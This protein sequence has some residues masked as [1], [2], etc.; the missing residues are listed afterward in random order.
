MHKIDHLGHDFWTRLIPQITHSS[1]V[2]RRTV[3]AAASVLD[4]FQSH[5]QDPS[6][7]IEARGRYRMNVRSIIKSAEQT[8][9]EFALLACLVFAS[10]ELVMGAL[11]AGRVHLEAGSKILTERIAYLSRNDLRRGLAAS[12]LSENI[13]PIFAAYSQV[14]SIN[15]ISLVS[16]GAPSTMWV[17]QYDCVPIPT[18]FVTTDQAYAHLRSTIHQIFVKYSTQSPAHFEQVQTQLDQW[19]TALD[20][21]ERCQGLSHTPHVKSSTICFFRNQHR[22]AQVFLSV[23]RGSEEANPLLLEDFSFDF[24]WIL[25][26]YDAMKF[27]Q[28]LLNE[29]VELIPPLFIIATKTRSK[30]ISNEAMRLLE[31][32][33]RVEANWDS[34]TALRI[35][36]ELIACEECSSTSP[37]SSSQSKQIQLPT[38]PEICLHN[39]SGMWVS[40]DSPQYTSGKLT[41]F[42]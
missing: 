24:I 22:L 9:P 30:G 41:I 6:A 16:M 4:S 2:V 28:V 37:A 7:Q 36:R 19:N 33:D 29:S 34:Q 38:S 35:A 18:I 10:C 3:I 40:T 25:A 5:S 32:M 17:G 12:M 21:L 20:A 13:L 39:A 23:A 26:Q 8:D 42:F 11:D 14:T 27:D 1:F 15:G 31:A